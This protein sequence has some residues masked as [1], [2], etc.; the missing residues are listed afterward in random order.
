MLNVLSLFDGGST[1]KVALEDLGLVEGVDFKYFS[2][3]VDKNAIK[4]SEDN[5]PGQI[6]RLGDVTKINYDNGVLHY[7]NLLTGAS[8]S[9]DV[10]KIDLLIGGSPCFTSEA[11]VLTLNGYKNIGSIKVGD[12]VLTHKGNWKRVINVG[13]KTAKITEVLLNTG[14][15]ILTTDN[16]PFYTKSD[17]SSTPEWT[18]A[19]DLSPELYN[20]FTVQHDFVNNSYKNIISRSA[21]QQRSFL[22]DFK[23]FDFNEKVSIPFSDIT[24]ALT[25]QQLLINTRNVYSPITTDKDTYVLNYNS[26][27]KYDVSD[28][29]IWEKIVVD[30][31]QT[32]TESI[33]YNLEV[34][35][36]NS[37]TVF[38][39]VVHNCQS[40]SPLGK[41]E[42]LEGKSGL[43]YEY[44]RI[45]RQV[46]QHN[47]NL[48]FLLENVKMRKDYKQNLDNYLGFVGVPI[49]SSLLS[50]Q[51]RSRVYWS[52]IPFTIPS[53]AGISFQDYKDT[54]EN[55]RQYKLP[56]NKST[57]GMWNN[58][59]GQ[60]NI[61]TGCANVT[62]ADKVYCLTTK[63]Y[64]NPNSGL[65]EYD[66]WCRFLTKEELELAQ[67]LPIGYTKS[68][69]YNQAQAV[70]GNGWTMKIISHIFKD[71]LNDK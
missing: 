8:E 22:T 6:T 57:T 31:N 17:L 29:C 63:Q 44:L 15:I 36:D 33:V 7:E 28:R 23:L 41:Q 47:P 48:K 69:S 35:D 3:E 45:L 55:Q 12:V 66:G 16:H 4:C 24:S 9:I 27:T 58:G 70:L 71:I 62:N 56:V 40:F 26:K 61:K 52:N 34:E 38:N 14:Q 59:N 37:Y 18:E 25:M 50:F 5:H 64:R 46:E 53:D 10:G 68:L 20:S 30:V 13:S 21:K 60:N 49:C 42:G 65:V 43:F 19:K 51:K 54:S 32:D 1:G 11:L 2:S 67:N 39:I